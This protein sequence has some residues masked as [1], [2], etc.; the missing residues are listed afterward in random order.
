MGRQVAARNRDHLA[1]CPLVAVMPPIVHY[2]RQFMA[3]RYRELPLPSRGVTR[4]A[5]A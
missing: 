3:L 2:N 4:R 5:L 1:P